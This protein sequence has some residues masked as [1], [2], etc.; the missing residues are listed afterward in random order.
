MLL[1][2]VEEG[3]L[4]TVD[5]FH[6]VCDKMLS[7]SYKFCP[8]VSVSEYED[9]RKDIRY[10]PSHVHI[11]NE[12]FSRIE[13]TRCKRW[14]KI[15]KCAPVNE[16]SAESVRCSSCRKLVRDLERSRTR[17]IAASPGRKQRRI[18]PSSHYPKKFLSPASQQK[19]T[20]IDKCERR[21]ERRLL[22]KYAPHEMILDDKQND[23]LVALV[24]EIENSGSEQLQAVFSEAEKHGVRSKME[25][26]WQ[27]DVKRNKQQFEADQRKNGN[28][29]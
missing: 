13:S 9:F 6:L 26:T 28:I 24:T 15:A 20:A 8:G 7:P 18:L 25:S 27:L 22:K 1:K 12:V 21:K 16:K 10:D 17:A 19:R 4:N 23:E 3:A 11:T 14:F 2:T 5:D 29:L